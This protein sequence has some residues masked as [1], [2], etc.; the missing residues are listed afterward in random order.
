MSVR[1]SHN[2]DS[3]VEHLYLAEDEEHLLIVRIKR[4]FHTGTIALS[5]RQNAGAF[6]VRTR[7]VL[8]HDTRGLQQFV[9]N[10]KAFSPLPESRRLIVSRRSIHRRGNSANDSLLFTEIAW[11]E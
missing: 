4:Y 9:V 1:T 2:K 7:N 3:T 6:A 11:N 8:L 10:D 5:P